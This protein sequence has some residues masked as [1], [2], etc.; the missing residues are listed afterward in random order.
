M[1]TPT[2][3]PLTMTTL[4]VPL[5]LLILGAYVICRVHDKRAGNR[6][7]DYGSLSD[8]ETSPLDTTPSRRDDGT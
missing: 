5:C 3:D 7:I 8:D 2:G 6:D 4:A 1:A